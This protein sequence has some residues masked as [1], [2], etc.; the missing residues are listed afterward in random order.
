MVA[1]HAAPL[2]PLRRG[3][4]APSPTRCETAVAMAAAQSRYW[5][6][7][8]PRV[9]AQLRRWERS[10]RAVRDPVLRDHALQKLR[11]E[12]ANTEAIATLCTLA[13]RRHRSAAVEAAVALQVMYDYLDA[14]TEA[15]PGD[16]TDRD[17]QLFRTFAVAL[18]PSEQPLD[19]YRYHCRRDDSGYLDQ[20]VAAAREAIARLP[21]TVAVLPVARDVAERFGEAQLRSH[22][23][24]HR[25]STQL[26]R[27]AAERAARVGVAWWE[28]AAGAAASVLGLHALLSA[29]ADVRTTRLQAVEID[30][31]YM[32]GST[33]TTMLDSLVDD[34]RDTAAGA[35]RYIA[36]YDTPAEAGC[37][38][39]AIARRA[40][41]AARELPH[42]AH[43]AITV[44]GIAAFYLSLPAARQRPARGVATRVLDE[45]GPVVVPLL[46]LFR[47]WRW[48]DG[49]RG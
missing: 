24:P 16:G 33:L 49:R 30:Y 38:M 44:A 10:A 17:R 11:D 18:T 28:W 9:R 6:T 8:A 36:Y 27:W 42:P 35:H 13:P 23:V 19:Y 37:R 21:A 3:R 41:A 25:G 39:A 40:V 29:A 4:I 20:L 34:E 5:L 32:L 14:V 2:R 43:H 7:V 1:V 31:A 12:R 47:T 22:A 45:L 15:E 46:L 48:I 26:E